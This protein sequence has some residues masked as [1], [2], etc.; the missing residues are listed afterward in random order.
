MHQQYIFPAQHEIMLSEAIK[1]GAPGD[2]IQFNLEASDELQG[3]QTFDLDLS[4]DT[5]LLEYINASGPNTVSFSEGH[6]HLSNDR[7]IASNNGI[8]TTLAFQVYLTKANSTNLIISNAHLNNFDPSFEE[9]LATASV[10]GNSPIFTSTYSCGDKTISDF[11]QGSSPFQ[12]V[13]MHPDPAIDQLTLDVDSKVEQEIQITIFDAFGK[14]QLTKQI[15][16]TKGNRALPLD[17][18]MLT[19]GMYIVDISN[20]ASRITTH[21]VKIQ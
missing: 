7:F 19:S 5:D 16:L 12:L 3:V 1:N 18:T 6:L 15:I 20:G 8:L 10:R 2:T 11:L 4:Y 17:L 13:A 9:C 21:F 14:K